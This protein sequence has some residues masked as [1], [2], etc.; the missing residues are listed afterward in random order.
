[1]QVV[2][3]TIG[4]V[5]AVVAVGW[6]LAGRKDLHIPT[7]ADLALLVTSPALMFS[8][9]AGTSLEPSQWGALAGGTVWI[10]AGTA[11]LVL[12]YVRTRGD[13]VTLGARR[14][15]ILPAVFWNAGNMGLACARLAFGP[16]GLEAGAIVFVVMAVLTSTFGIWIA[17][18]EN[19]VME[20]LRLPLL[21][22]SVG[23][24]A[25]ALTGTSL[26]K[27]VM[28]PI[29]M[30]GAMAIPLMLLN[31]GA[32]LRTLE[33]TDLRHSLVVVAIRMG[34]GVACAALFV[35][36]FDVTGID[37]QV[38]LLNSIM[39]AAVINVV[40]AQRYDANPAAVASAIVLSTLLSL[41]TIP[42]IL[43]AT[44]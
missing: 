12:L 25:L 42:A 14:G 3:G 7:L 18:G 2:L 6:L 28:E 19:G 43:L 17:K 10:A 37:R 29:E 35:T 31:L 33:V 30:L 5:F 22:G 8:V 11:L 13:G 34:G 1:V 9:L 38:L 41:L 44:T 39:P 40:L 32:Q 4:P 36:L 26:P 21:Y 24:I 15:L 27:P 20:V 23:G 16:A